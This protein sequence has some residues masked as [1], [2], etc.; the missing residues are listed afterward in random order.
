MEYITR[1]SVTSTPTPQSW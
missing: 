1:V